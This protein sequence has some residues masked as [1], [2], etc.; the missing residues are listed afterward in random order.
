M[1]ASLPSFIWSRRVNV[2]RCSA[3][4]MVNEF[5]LDK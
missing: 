5:N 2:R 3:S 1:F 4:Q